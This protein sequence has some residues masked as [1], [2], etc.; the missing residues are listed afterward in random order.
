MFS[1]KSLELTKN[2]EKIT[3][4]KEGIFFTPKSIIEK[5]IKV[6]EPYFKNIKS[7]LEPS[8]GSCAYILEINK[9]Y[10]DLKIIGI[11]NNQ[12][13]YNSIKELSNNNIEIK[14]GDY[15]KYETSNKYDLIIGNPPFVVI[16]NDIV[17]DKY[18]SY[19]DNRPNL[20]ILFIIKSLEQ[21]NDG[22]ILSFILPKNFINCMYYNKTRKYISDNYN[23]IDII[24][25]SE[26]GNSS[27]NDNKKGYEETE[28]NTIL[29]IIQN[30]KKNDNSKFVI[31][32]SYKIKKK[33]PKQK[34]TYNITKY[35]IIFVRISFVFFRY[36][37]TRFI[38]LIK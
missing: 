14:H 16:D 25:F 20:F 19:Y 6:L 1:T 10:P 28:Q 18:L 37:Y 24:D 27:K 11:E 36:W 9:Q 23:I 33:I 17:D 22:G 21:L 2:I 4:N 30:T 7:V 12:T 13:I 31:T 32:K 29:L 38:I 3:K 34:K 26:I 35:I 15:L 5:N 8:C